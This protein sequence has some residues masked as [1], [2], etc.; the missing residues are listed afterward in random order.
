M[1]CKSNIEHVTLQG[2]MAD[3]REQANLAYTSGLDAGEKRILAQFKS[4]DGEFVATPFDLPV[5]VTQEGLQ[6]LCN[7]AL[8]NVSMSGW[9]VGGDWQL[10]CKVCHRYNVHMFVLFA[11][12][13]VFR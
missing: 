4:E 7:A 9:S 13:L 10:R 12:S 2:K 1:Q 6:L 3:S 8:Q 5:D 11:S